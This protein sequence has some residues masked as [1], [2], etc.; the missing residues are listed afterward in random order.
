MWKK[1]SIINS[2][3]YLKT[4]GGS[5]QRHMIDIQLL[6]ILNLGMLLIPSPVGTAMASPQH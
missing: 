1:W 4:D 2:A 5:P 3:P 6:A